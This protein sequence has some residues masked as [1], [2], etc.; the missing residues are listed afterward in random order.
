M[1]EEH[2]LIVE[3]NPAVTWR[4]EEGLRQ[5]FEGRGR[6]RIKLVVLGSAEDSFGS[7]GYLGE[8]HARV[9]LGHCPAP[10]IRYFRKFTKGIF[11]IT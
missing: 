1:Q 2:P 4:E 9:T 11:M 3:P 5:L 8:R 7:L 10:H 6:A